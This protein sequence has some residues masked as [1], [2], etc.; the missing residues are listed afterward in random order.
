MD[1]QA[2]EAVQ[3]RDRIS[4]TM[5]TVDFKWNELHGEKGLLDSKKSAEY[6][7]GEKHRCVFGF[8]YCSQ[9]EADGTGVDDLLQ[10]LDVVS[11]IFFVGWSGG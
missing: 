5:Y 1:Y 2:I 11:W 10:V 4:T 6:F 8:C 3:L 7:V 9:L